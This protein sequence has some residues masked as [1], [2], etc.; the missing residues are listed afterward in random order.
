MIY[1][2]ITA[3]FNEFNTKLFK[4]VLGEEISPCIITLNRKNKTFSGNYFAHYISL[5]KSV[6]SKS[7]LFLNPDYFG[8]RPRIELLQSLVHEMMHLYQHEHGTVVKV[9]THDEQFLDFMN[10]IGLM[11][12]SNG[13][14]DGK[15]IGGK[16]FFNYPLPGGEFL[17]V[18]NGLV[19]RDLFPNWFVSTTPSDVSIDSIIKDLY[20]IK[21]L[22]DGEVDPYLLEVPLLIKNNIDVQA[23]LSC[24]TV[25]HVTQRVDLD[26][27]KASALADRK[28]EENKIND[29][30]D[31]IYQEP[32]LSST[33]VNS[34]EG[35]NH[36]IYKEDKYT[37][38]RFDQKINNE[39]HKS[40]VSDESK[41]EDEM[42][43]DN[44][45]IDPLDSSS[46]GIDDNDAAGQFLKALERKVDAGSS[47][48]I[49]ESVPIKQK[50]EVLPR[51]VHSAD[52]IASIL[53]LK[54]AAAE[55]P[56]EKKKTRYK[57]TCPCDNIIWGG[58][59]MSVI[60]GVCQ[61]HFK[62]ETLDVE[63]DVVSK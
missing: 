59:S 19:E 42:L 61:L 49:N 20:E 50:K 13:R 3:L 55:K 27:N 36:K 15:N 12:S 1:E 54:S 62:C 44:F 43:G 17:T 31:E 32:V 11:P 56:A 14:P 38:G 2:Q 30:K 7:E 52:E 46:V 22:L 18:C 6:S 5:D 35:V 4:A 23:L 58:L 16:N 47:D 9:G 34:D 60:C 28:I 51:V 37:A 8:V 45:V 57:Y 48:P 26:R 63:K 24:L 40:V 39:K 29:V 41:Q 53:G 10:A 25:D 21:E 33:F